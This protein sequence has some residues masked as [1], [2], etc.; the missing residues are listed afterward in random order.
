LLLGVPLAGCSFLFD[1]DTLGSPHYGASDGAS[2]AS[3]ADVV[4]ADGPIA[5]FRLADPHGT[6]TPKNEISG[7]ITGAI[8][9]GVTFGV[10]GLLVG[11]VGTAASFNGTSSAMT[12]APSEPLRF[13]GSVPFSLEAWVSPN[14][15]DADYRR[16]FSSEDDPNPGRGW[17][18]YFVDLQSE[19]GSAFVRMTNGVGCATPRADLRAGMPN[20]IVAVFDDALTIHYYVNGVDHASASP[21]RDPIRQQNGLILGETPGGGNN[22]GGVIEHLAIYAKAL[23]ADRVLAHWHAGIGR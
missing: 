6:T 23:T 9:G 4:G 22:F 1:A 5:Y 13:Q 7:A 11:D 12:L 21:C 19:Q 2:P 17:Q 16:I 18:G 3:Y 8:P 10:A 20:H 15:I 14:L